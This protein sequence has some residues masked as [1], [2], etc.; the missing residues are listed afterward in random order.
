MNKLI[1]LPFIIGC[2]WL[3]GCG[4]EPVYQ[5][6]PS[7]SANEN[8]QDTSARTFLQSIK[9][10]QIPN[11]SGQYMRN[12]LID[13]FYQTGY[14]TDP[15]YTLKIENFKETRTDLDINVNSAATRAQ[16]DLS[17]MMVLID[18]KTAEPVLKRPISSVVSY[19]ILN[20]QFT[21]RVSATS[22]RRNAIQDLVGQIENHLTLY[23]RSARSQ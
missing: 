7:L 15:A 22:T 12:E 16:L 20:S 2:L 14:P 3:C 6:K 11:E 4:F 10:A 17:G 18:N 9:I 8:T 13:R 19:N 5:E 21:T 23:A 1:L